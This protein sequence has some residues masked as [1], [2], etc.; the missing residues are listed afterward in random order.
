[1]HHQFQ[2]LKSLVNAWMIADEDLSLQ[3]ALIRLLRSHHSTVATAESC[4]GG[5]IAHLITSIP[6]SSSVFNGSVVSY[7]N[8]AKEHL[9]GVQHQTLLDHGAVSEN[10]VREMVHG[11]IDKLDTTYA[12]A[13]SGIMGP[14][15]GSAEKPVGTVWM[16]VGNKQTVK[17][18]KHFFRF[19]RHRNIEMAAHAAMTM[20]FR[21]I[22][23]QHNTH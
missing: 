2:K 1:V 18:V 10:T 12:I 14:D 9:L 4:T 22:S 23:E 17:A 5:Y 16:A 20:L 8:D 21:F 11:A 15:G 3:E 7:S 6:G 13:T 19:D